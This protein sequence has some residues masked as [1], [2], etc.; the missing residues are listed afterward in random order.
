MT[1]SPPDEQAGPPPFPVHRDPADAWV[2][3]E[4]GERYWGL[5]GAAGL[6]VHDPSK[7]V[8]LQHRASWSHHGGTW[9]LP[10]GARHLGES[11]LDGALREAAEEAAVPRDAVRPLATHVLDLEIW[12]YTT[13][14]ALAISPFDARIADAESL[15]L[16][17]IAPDEVPGLELHPGLAHAWPQ[18]RGLL[19]IR[20]ALVVDTANVLGAVP[21]GWWKDRRGATARLL[22]I[23]E[24]VASTGLP[25]SAFGVETARV[26]PRTVAV[27]EGT[28]RGARAAGALEVVDAPRDG[29]SEVLAQAIALNAEGYE[30]TVVSSDRGLIARLP[31]GV[32]A[33]G[34]GW[35]RGM[36]DG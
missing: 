20:A 36:I 13:V 24:P 32:C 30:V 5:H 21:D 15:S 25:G 22:D 19:D 27:L 35:L 16:E 34:S 23:L 31:A 9:G 12:S 26:T 7:G 33:R 11:A 8:L 6:L 4:S 14:V 28:A 1:S 2:V 3:A 18:L 29:D 17:W 10:G